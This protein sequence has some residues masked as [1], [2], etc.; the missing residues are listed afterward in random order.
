MSPGGVNPG[1]VN[2][3]VTRADATPVRR[4][5]WYDLI[6]PQAAGL[7]MPILVLSIVMTF[8]ALHHGAPG[9]VARLRELPRNFFGLNLL[10]DFS[11]LILLGVAIWILSRV[12]DPQIPARFRPLSRHGLV[13]GVGAGLGAVLVSSLAEYLSDRYLHTNLGQEGVATAIL[14]HSADQLLLGL[15]SVALLGPMTEEA[16]FR[17]LVLGWLERHCGLFWSVALSALLFGM[18]HLKWLAPGGLNGIVGTAELVAMGVLLAVVAARTGSLWASFIT[19]ATNNLFAAL[20]A[21][22]LSH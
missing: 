11:N 4:V 15:F 22:L 10:L 16:Y 18:L 19:H 14:P 1:G 20:V 12:N 7:G 13:V 8:A 3:D 21:V 5:R 17:G 2:Q 9:T 6:I